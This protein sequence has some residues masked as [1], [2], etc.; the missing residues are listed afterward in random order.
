L[1]DGPGGANGASAGTPLP[2][3]LADFAR[4][5]E[6]SAAMLRTYVAYQRGIHDTMVRP[7]PGALSMI[8]SLRAAGTHV[9]IVTSKG[10]SIA[11]RTMEVCEIHECVDVVV[12]GDEV[13]RGKPHP[14]PVLRAMSA[15]GLDDPGRVLFVGDST[16][17][18]R[19]GRAAGTCTAAA[20][21]GPI[22]RS[23]LAAE[24]PD[25]FLERLEDVLTVRP[26]GEARRLEISC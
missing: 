19:A 7:F 11:R 3:Q 1:T 16:H 12:C 24:R 21:W 5:E 14:E 22:E 4:N 9:G 10:T 20:G 23:V 6:E 17:D 26:P 15:L 13:K 2:L 8:G 25:Y 18:L